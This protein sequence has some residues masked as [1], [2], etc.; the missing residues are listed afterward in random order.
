MKVWKFLLLIMLTFVVDARTISKWLTTRWIWV[1]YT[2]RCL[3]GSIQVCQG[4]VATCVSSSAIHAL[5]TPTR[6]P[7]SVYLLWS[8]HLFCVV[9]HYSVQRF[10]ENFYV[11]SCGLNIVFMVTLRYQ[12]GNAVLFLDCFF[13]FLFF[14]NTFFLPSPGWFFKNLLFRIALS[15]IENLLFLVFTVP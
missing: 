1:V 11:Q 14:L 5:T 2:R 9:F 12:C 10:F 8:V 7:A 15:I 4:F 3:W 6:D 13:I